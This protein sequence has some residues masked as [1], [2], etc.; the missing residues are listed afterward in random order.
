[1]R[2]KTQEDY[3]TSAVFL[4]V[5]GSLLVF[6]HLIHW[7]RTFFQVH[8]YLKWSFTETFFLSIMDQPA[9]SVRRAPFWSVMLMEGSAMV[10]E[11]GA[12]CL[13]IYLY[14]CLF[15]YFYWCMINSPCALLVLSNS[16]PNYQRKMVLQNFISGRAGPEESTETRQKWKNARRLP[17][18]YIC[19]VFLQM[20]GSLLVFFCLCLVSVH[21]SG[22]SLLEMEFSRSYFPQY[23]QLLCRKPRK[24]SNKTALH[25]GTVSRP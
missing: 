14:V 25:F 7:L 12:I 21:F 11:H 17:Y 15:I 22:P 23:S 24:C 3:L 5:Y 18:M 4:Q 16:L 20:Q 1:M 8:P 6:F 10:I 2:W 9:M 13:L 19:C